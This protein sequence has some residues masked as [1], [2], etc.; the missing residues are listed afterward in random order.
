MAGQSLGR[1]AQPYQLGDVQVA[2]GS[3]SHRMA[4]VTVERNGK[5]C[6]GTAVYHDIVVGARPGLCGWLQ[7]RGAVGGG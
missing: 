5:T 3:V 2:A 6:R 1:P 4:A 7:Q